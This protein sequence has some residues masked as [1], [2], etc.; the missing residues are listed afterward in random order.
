VR[1]RCLLIFALC[2]LSFSLLFLPGIVPA[3]APPAS[4]TA[5]VDIFKAKFAGSNNYRADQPLKLTYTLTN[6]ST[7]PLHILIWGTPLE[8]IKSNMFDITGPRGKVRYV[9]PLVSRIG[10][11]PSDYMTI[12]PRQSVSRVVDLA[13][14]YE[15]V[16]EGAYLVTPRPRKMA[17]AVRKPS[18]PG[19]ADAINF[20]AVR[21]D[22]IRFSQSGR[23]VLP[24]RLRPAQPSTRPIVTP[25]NLTVGTVAQGSIYREPRFDL[26]CSGISPAGSILTDSAA[27]ASAKR[28]YIEALNLA[29]AAKV[30][31]SGTTPEDFRRG[32]ERYR[33]YF[34]AYAPDTLDWVHSIYGKIYGF[35]FQQAAPDSCADTFTRNFANDPVFI[36][37]GKPDRNLCGCTNVQQGDCCA[38]QNCPFCCDLPAGTSGRCCATSAGYVMSDEITWVGGAKYIYLCP[39]FWTL[40]LTAAVDSQAGVIL[41]EMS[42]LANIEIADQ[43]YTYGEQLCMA[44]ANSNPQG[45]F[46]NADN[47]HRF[48][49][50]LNGLGM[51]LERQSIKL[52]SQGGALVAQQGGGGVLNACGTVGSSTAVFGVSNPKQNMLVYDPASGSLKGIRAAVPAVAPGNGD[53][54]KLITSNRKN[55]VATTM[56]RGGTVRADDSDSQFYMLKKVMGQPGTAIQDGD[57][58]ALQARGGLYLAAKN[59]DVTMAGEAATGT[60]FKASVNEVNVPR[61]YFAHIRTSGN[62]YL[63]AENGGGGALNARQRDSSKCTDCTFILVDRNGGDLKSGDSVFLMTYD[64]VH[65]VGETFQVAPRGGLIGMTA[66]ASVAAPGQTFV[67][68]KLS[69]SRTAPQMG[70]EII[71][72]GDRIRLRSG[73]GS[74]YLQAVNGGGSI[75]S[76]SGSVPVSVNRPPAT[77]ASDTATHFIIELGR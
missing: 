21:T 48:A 71:H 6:N 17:F 42:H 16:D 44:L 63:A 4:G 25:Y 60:I 56:S 13:E 33:A 15:I 47:F 27:I 39:V 29:A 2:L 70:A 31:L 9:G 23:R 22:A 51:G 26:M 40:P 45:A 74:S 12:P 24:G 49:M 38:E 7:G 66:G 41:H 11:Y 59:C 32:A 36:Y 73:S 43:D 55:V 75:V 50:N 35:G 1:K 52:L 37:M 58:V 64:G 8:G 67:I 65:Y 54:V 5:T 76:M 3:Q 77:G 10:P 18:R 19:V 28:A 34:G 72:T 61:R 62:Y 57:G 53:Q 30:S 20:K 46:R 69:P 68:E 14:A